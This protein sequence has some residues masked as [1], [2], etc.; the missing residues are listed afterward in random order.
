M[1]KKIKRSFPL[2][3]KKLKKSIPTRLYSEA[4]L[5]FKHFFKLFIDKFRSLNDIPIADVLLFFTC[6]FAMIAA[7]LLMLFFILLF[8]I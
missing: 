8:T 4:V 3:L 2:L 6:L 7:F 5:G 1:L